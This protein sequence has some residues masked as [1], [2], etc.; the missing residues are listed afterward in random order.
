MTVTI[1]FIFQD[2]YEEFTV[3]IP[4]L[5]VETEVCIQ[6]AHKKDLKEQQYEV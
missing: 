1:A 3:L 6:G 4:L 5:V 2:I